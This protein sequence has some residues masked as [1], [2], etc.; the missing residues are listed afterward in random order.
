M[1]DMPLNNEPTTTTSR[2]VEQKIWASWV[3]PQSTLSPFL[4]LGTWIK[5][6]VSSP[7]I[8]RRYTRVGTRAP[9]LELRS[10]QSQPPLWNSQRSVWCS[11]EE[12]NALSTELQYLWKGCGH[13]G[14]AH[15]G[16]GVLGRHRP[17]QRRPPHHPAVHGGCGSPGLQVLH[18]PLRCASL[19][20]AHCAVMHVRCCVVVRVCL[21]SHAYLDMAEQHEYLLSHHM[22]ILQASARTVSRRRHAWRVSMGIRLLARCSYGL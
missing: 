4:N 10:T 19:L 16:H 18:D 20:H 2:L 15:G 9:V 22:Q 17:G 12:Y 5:G 1:I 3:R 8:A 11:A 6:P 7:S 21:I 13:A 14:G